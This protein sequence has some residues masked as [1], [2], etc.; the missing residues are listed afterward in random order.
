MGWQQRIAELAL[1]GGTL[2]GQLGCGDH[3]IPACN[4]NPDPCCSDPSGS[5]CATVTRERQ[6][7]AAAGGTY[8]VGGRVCE[9]PDGGSFSL[10][11]G[12]T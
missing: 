3:A 9:L 6:E 12:G 8:F 7:C 11:D 2:I 1:A 5:V 10:P 4:A